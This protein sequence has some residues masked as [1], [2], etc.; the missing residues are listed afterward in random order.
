MSALYSLVCEGYSEENT[1]HH[2][3]GHDRTVDLRSG[4]TVRMDDIPSMFRD[5]GLV[6]AVLF[7]VRYTRMGMPYQGWGS[8][9]NILIEIVDLLAPLDRLYHPRREL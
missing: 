5:R 1:E 2:L 6:S 3:G 8:N 9:P 4:A 7:Y